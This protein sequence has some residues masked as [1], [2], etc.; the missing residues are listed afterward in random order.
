MK[1]FSLTTEFPGYFQ[2]TDDTKLKPGSLVQGSQN[3]LIRDGLSIETRMGYTLDG[4]SNAAITPIESSYEWITHRGTELAIRSY[5]DELEWRYVNSTGDVT[6]TRLADSFTAVDFN[7][8]EWWD[9]TEGQDALLI[10][11]GSSNVY[12]WSGAYTTFASAT[13]NTITKEGTTTWAEEGFLTTGTRGVIINGTAYTYTGGESTTTLTGVSPD[14]TSAGHTA[15]DLVFQ[16]LRTTAN[17]SIT[18]LPNTFN[19]DL[20]S[21]L[22]NQVYI[23][24]L[25]SREV[26]VSQNDSYTTFS[27]TATR[28]PG[29]GAILTLDATPIGFIPQEQDMYISAGKNYWYKT[30]FAISADL[31]AENLT[32]K[33]LKTGSQEAAKSQSAITSIKNN[34]AYISNE[35]TLDELGRLENIDTPQSKPLSDLIKDLFGSLDFTNVHI[36][37]FKNQIFIALPAEGKVLIF[38]LENGYWQPPQIIPARRLSIISDEIYFHSSATPETFKLFSGRNDN[39]SAIEAKAVFSYDNYGERAN[40]KDFDVFYTEGYMDIGANLNLILRYEYQGAGRAS[41]FIIDGTDSDILFGLSSSGEL[42]TTPLGE[43]PLGMSGENNSE[44]S[45]PSKFRIKNTFP[46][47]PFFELQVEYNSNDEDRNWSIVAFGPNVRLATADTLKI[48]K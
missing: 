6:W 24:S 19:N 40:F 30:N 37:Y 23:G 25:T 33:R 22:D 38:D 9:A 46:T 4:Q 42:G 29:E 31:T 10:V 48:K 34:V 28:V 7:F 21:V 18:D 15:G 3:V 27:F 11:N 41:E 12:Y 8:A 5:D 43:S 1:K 45:N 36:K 16:Q 2:K 20:I 17:S 35:P 47:T 39:S 26:Y 13:S 32:V 44:D 14:P